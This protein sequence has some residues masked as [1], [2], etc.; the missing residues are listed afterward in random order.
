MISKQI[1]GY[2]F[3]LDERIF[4]H[5]AGSVMERYFLRGR[6]EVFVPPHFYERARRG[7]R[8]VERLESPFLCDVFDYYLQEVAWAA[9]NSYFPPFEQLEDG[10]AAIQNA[11]RQL[12]VCALEMQRRGLEWPS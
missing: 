1:P 5:V 3:A 4:M 7:N 10:S 8:L 6:T 9:A 12:V 11:L 2:H